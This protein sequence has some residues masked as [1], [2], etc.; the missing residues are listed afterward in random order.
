MNRWLRIIRPLLPPN[1]LVTMLVVSAIPFAV[2]MIWSLQ[3][4]FI[5]G[6]QVD[7]FLRVRDI[8]AI[9]VVGIYG[10]WRAGSGHPLVDEQY[11]NWLIHSPWL[12]DKNRLP[13]G[14]LIPGPRDVVVLCIFAAITAWGGYAIYSTLVAFLVAWTFV[15]AMV[16]W[17]GGARIHAWII[18]LVV[19]SLPLL[20][21][22]G[23]LAWLPLLGLLPV[24]YDGNMRCLRTL[25]KHQRIAG[26]LKERLKGSSHSLGWPF[27][28][29]YP[30]P[31][32]VELKTSDRLFLGMT[33]GLGTA[34][35]VRLLEIGNGRLMPAMIGLAFVIAITCV[36]SRLFSY[37]RGTAP[38]ISW[39]GRVR[40]RRL[41]IPGYDRVFV[42]PL[43]SV[44]VSL[45]LYAIGEGQQ[46][47]PAP[48]SGAI[49]ASAI[50]LNLMGRP[51]L[52]DWQLTGHFR[53]KFIQDPQKTFVNLGS[54]QP[55][56]G[57]IG[58]PHSG[59]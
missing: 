20:L 52:L 58:Q 45:C 30:M 43:L 31:P 55:T 17:D 29:L 6:V 14:S 26:P 37:L 25:R 18:L 53:H 47:E 13:F 33:C 42:I 41:I 54:G 11:R 16:I 1:W 27:A 38:P 46:L 5:A 44:L 19:S 21:D 15:A 22:L 12:P 3:E 56:D 39:L 7:Q 35:I 49:V 57:K 28:W 32:A 2:V 9:I 59:S 51:R 48:I 4:P 36:V 23:H 8:W 24:I 50:L 34:S 40:T 10:M